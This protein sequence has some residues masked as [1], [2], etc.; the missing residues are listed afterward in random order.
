MNLLNAAYLWRSIF[1][2]NIAFTTPRAALGI[3]STT[4]SFFGF[5]GTGHPRISCMSVGVSYWPAIIR[6][7]PYLNLVC[8]SLSGVMEV[9]K[10]KARSL[11]RR[12]GLKNLRNLRRLKSQVVRDAAEEELK[13][14]L[15]QLKTIIWNLYFCRFNYGESIMT[16][17][18]S[19]YISHTVAL[20]LLLDV[21]IS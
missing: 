21:I 14:I 19:L 5:A 6:C 16:V 10:N 11:Q 9:I 20:F 1:L 13:E 3:T 4:L 15:D 8:L 12:S 17:K 18:P 2:L 7:T